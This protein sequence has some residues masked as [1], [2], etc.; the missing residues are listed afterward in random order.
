VSADERPASFP[1][2]R[3]LDELWCKGE[4]LAAAGM[5]LLMGGLVFAQVVTKVFGRRHEW[6]DVAILFVVVLLGVRTRTVKEGE[7]KLDWPRSLGVAVAITAGTAFVV[8][9]YVRQVPT[10]LL[11]AQ[12]VAM[13]L[14]I[15]VAMLGASIATY[16]RSHLSLEMGEKIW[17][18][19]ILHWVKAFAHAVTAAFSFAFLAVS[20][21]MV[22]SQRARGT[23]IAEAVTAA[24][25]IPFIHSLPTWVAFLIVP[26]AFASMAVRFLGQAVTTATGTDAPM[27]DRLPS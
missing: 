2:I 18:K 17:P 24:D 26:Y 1:R 25:P 13:V 27:E 4:R 15:W 8:W 22:S 23:H 10:G 6:T 14:L 5:F 11:W 21:E 12:K 3:R 7:Q 16:D 19:K 20:V 9:L